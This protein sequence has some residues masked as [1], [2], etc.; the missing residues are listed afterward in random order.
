MTQTSPHCNY[1]FGTYVYPVIPNAKQIKTVPIQISRRNLFSQPK[2]NS[3]KNP[4]I[5]VGNLLGL[6]NFE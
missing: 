5:S 3:K 2:H 1:L 4:H 6:N